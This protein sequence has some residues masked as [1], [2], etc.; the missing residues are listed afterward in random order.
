M[1]GRGIT[2]NAVAPGIIAGGMS[3]AVFDA[4]AIARLVPM[5]RAGSAEEVASLVGYLASAEAGVHHRSDH[6]DQRRNDLTSGVGIHAQVSRTRQLR[7]GIQRTR[8]ARGPPH[9]APPRLL[10]SARSEGG[11]QS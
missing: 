5:K 4:A 1:A 6:L 8:R 3:E 11:A 10:G 7:V 2:V 9:P